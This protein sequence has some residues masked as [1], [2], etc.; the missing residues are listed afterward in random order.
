MRGGKG[1]V[2]ETMSYGDGART[3]YMGI[4]GQ[5]NGGLSEAAPCV[6]RGK[7][8]VELKPCTASLHLFNFPTVYRH[9]GQKF[10]GKPLSSN[11][12]N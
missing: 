6:S 7:A 3:P 1:G 11:R 2:S 10:P 4:C 8:G 12:C 5:G 9:V